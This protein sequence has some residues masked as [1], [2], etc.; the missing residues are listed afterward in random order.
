[1]QWWCAAQGVPWSWD[2]Q[3]YPGVWLFA[4]ML[5]GVFRLARRRYPETDRPRFRA[6]MYGLGVAALWVALDWPVGALGAGYLA[7]VHM[8]QYLLIA[9]IA[10]PLLLMGVPRGLYRALANGLLGTPL[11]VL[12][13]PISAVIVF[14]SIMA[15]THWPP[16]VDT[17][18]VSQIGS[19]VLDFVWLL[20]GLVF[21]WPVV[22]PEPQRSWLTEPAKV[23][24]LIAA[25]LVNTGVFAY[26]TFSPLPL[27]ATY[28]LAPPVS[29][30]STRDDQL[31]AG[32]LMKMGGAVILWTAISIIFFRWVGRSEREDRYVTGSVAVVLLALVA[33]CGPGDPEASWLELGPVAVRDARVGE[34][35]MPDRAALYFDVRTATGVPAG[36]GRVVVRGVEVDGAERAEIHETSL[37]D[38]MMRMRPVDSLVLAAGE[39]RTLAPGGLHVML[40]DL[41]EPLRAGDSVRVRLLLADPYGVVEFSA[42][43]IPLEALGG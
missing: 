5:V 35:P 2:W 19:F 36:S 15:W 33:A 20:S 23:G 34:P 41:A 21:W 9:M 12:S 29:G 25:T 28:E 16:V 7:S 11:R 18:M 1:M 3:A 6:W 32:L 10:P 13:H 37:T 27:Y 14:V 42:P 17:L 4:L 38:G 43:V 30:L 39:E 8:V 24:Y 26:L 40:L 22:A 31:V